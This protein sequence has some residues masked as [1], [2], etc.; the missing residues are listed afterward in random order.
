MSGLIKV[1]K[2]EVF[3]FFTLYNF[4]MYFYVFCSLLTFL[5]LNTD[6]DNL[7]VSLFVF[8]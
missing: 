2:T 7:I 8:L 5:T 4:L 1:I 3:N 6:T